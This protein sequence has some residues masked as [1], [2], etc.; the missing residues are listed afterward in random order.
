MECSRCG[1][2]F[3]C[4]DDGT[5]T[6]TF[7]RLETPIIEGSWEDYNLCEECIVEFRRWWKEGKKEE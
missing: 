7:D 1:Y 4:D 6:E 3:K 2:V 5:L